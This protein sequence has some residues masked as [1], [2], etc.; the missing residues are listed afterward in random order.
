MAEKP[1]ASR[2][3]VRSRT[4]GTVIA[5]LAALLVTVVLLVAGSPSPLR[6][7][8]AFFGGPFSNIYYLGNMLDG[9][10]LLLI[11]G[12]GVGLAFR[13]GVFNLGGDGQIYI[14]GLVAAIVCLAIP[15]APAAAGIVLA[16]G[17]AVLVGALLAGVC[18]LFKYLWDTDELITSFL[19]S[20]ALVPTVSF[21]IAGPLRNQQS[22]LLT[23]VRIAERFRLLRIL[24]PSNLNLALFAALLLAPAA[25]FLLYHTVRGYELRITGLNREFAR[26]GGIAVG[27]YTVVPMAISGGLHGLTGAFAVL[28]THHAAI[29]GFTFG[30][31]W[32]AIAVALIGRNHPLL[33]VPAALVFA[34]MEAGSK[35]AMLHTEFSFELASIIQAVIFFMI[36][37]QV[38]LPRL[39]PRLRRPETAA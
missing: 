33:L 14:S 13:A 12:L 16:T 20:A 23:T 29:E 24:P 1:A 26:Y 21:L 8:R 32:N 2:T 3:P 22:N 37:A 18:G 4:P 27:A 30:L 10:G 39:R 15:E 19:I 28:G 36:T 7:L 38:A 31:G 9:A 34:Y 11:A 6:A 17:S 5:L 25:Y 35:A